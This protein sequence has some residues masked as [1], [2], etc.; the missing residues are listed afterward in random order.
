MVVLF[1]CSSIGNHRLIIEFSLKQ[2][3]GFNSEIT[4]TT[5]SH[6]EQYVFAGS[7]SGTIVVWDIEA[8]KV[9]MNFKEHLSQ[10]MCIAAQ[11]EFNGPYLVSGSLDTN[12]KTWDLRSKKSMMT[13]KSHSKPI[14][15]VDISVDGRIVASGSQDTY[16]KIW[17]NPSSRC[18]HQLRHSQIAGVT[19]IAINPK[20]VSLVAGYSDRFLRYWDLDIGNMICTTAPCDTTPVQKFWFSDDGATVLAGMSDSIKVWD[21]EQATM[22]DIIMK[23]QSQIY[24]IKQVAEYNSVGSSVIL[25]QISNQ[26]V[27]LRP[28][29]LQDEVVTSLTSNEM[30][31]KL[32][33]ID[34]KL[35]FYNNNNNKPNLKQTQ[36]VS[37]ANLN[38]PDKTP[39]LNQSVQNQMKSTRYVE[40]IQSSKGPQSSVLAKNGFNIMTKIKKQSTIKNQFQDSLED[41]NSVIASTKRLPS[42]QENSNKN[43]S[44]DPMRMTSRTNLSSLYEIPIDKPLNLDIGKFLQ[45]TDV[46]Y[47]GN[48]IELIQEA[49]KQSQVMD[50]ILDKRQKNLK[51]VLKWWGQ[52]NINSTINCLSQLNDLSV[53]N[54]FVADTFAVNSKL[55]LLNMENTPAILAHCLRLINSKYES[56]SNTGIRAYNNI[57]KIFQDRIMQAKSIIVS[58]KVDI[59]REKRMEKIDAMI[60]Q[61]ERILTAQGWDRALKSQNQEIRELAAK[62]D[63]DLDFFIEKCKKKPVASNFNAK[64]D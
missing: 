48:D 20:D 37:Q 56:H 47:N 12:V 28:A 30:N 4:S 6:N 55:D 46:K 3:N 50:R 14:T 41:F 63:N 8:Q 42:R 9:A 60:D 32:P 43:D 57:F 45:P 31:S 2:Y 52:G 36:R 1:E 26:E 21:I 13:C 7:Y 58:D 22:I 25:S 17:E 27:N 39:Q 10:V 54:D 29:D 61:F 23:P 5:F 16:V 49:M 18:I 11:R 33:S 35:D 40:N 34:Q 24:D 53:V 59:E 62:L 51:T 19:Q 38:N 44:I 15:S 64:F